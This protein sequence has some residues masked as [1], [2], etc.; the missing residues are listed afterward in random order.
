MLVFLGTEFPLLSPFAWMGCG[1]CL[2]KIVII[3]HA[4]FT[5]FSQ[6]NRIPL[7]TM[8]S[9]LQTLDQELRA[10]HP[11]P[12]GGCPPI[13]SRP[14]WSTRLQR[15]MAMITKHVKELDSGIPDRKRQ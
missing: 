9:E 4:G 13:L 5:R 1:I 10:T 3:A 15:I 2:S 7:Q 12:S 14:A 11:V 6:S 8:A